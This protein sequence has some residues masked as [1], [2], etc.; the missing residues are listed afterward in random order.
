[1]MLSMRARVSAALLCGFIGWGGCSRDARLAGRNVRKN[2]T[3]RAVTH[4][5]VTLDQAASP[6]QVAYVL[7]R[8]IRDDFAA[9]GRDERDAAIDKQF[10]L[11]AGNVIAAKNRTGMS[12]SEFL[13]HVVHRW[14]PTVSHYVYDFETRWDQAKKRFVRLGPRAAKGSDSGAM[15]CE[16]IMEVDAPSGDPNARVVLVV[17]FA[18]DNGFWRV[19]HLGFDPTRRSIGS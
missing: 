15:E 6:E 18:R 13:F 19:V 17:Y 12:R 9:S 10:D 11:C 7:L 14:T 5:G 1:M 3:V 2:V 16:V 4:F 8:A